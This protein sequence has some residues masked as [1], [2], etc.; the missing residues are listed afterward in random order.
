MMGTKRNEVLTDDV[1][2]GRVG[3]RRLRMAAVLI[4]LGYA[5]LCASLFFKHAVALTV[6]IPAGGLLTMV[7]IGLWLRVVI[8]EIRAK[9]LV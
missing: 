5:A 6:L 2:V 1:V 8:A 4:V 3:T 9:G 7:G